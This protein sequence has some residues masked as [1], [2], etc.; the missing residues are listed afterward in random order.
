MTMEK[1]IYDEIRFWAAVIGAL[2]V[3]FAIGTNF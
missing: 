2:I 3:G 1:N